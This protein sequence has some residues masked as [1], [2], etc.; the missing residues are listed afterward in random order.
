MLPSVTFTS[1]YCPPCTQ[2]TVVVPGH[3]GVMAVPVSVLLF[4]HWA[5][6]LCDPAH[7]SRNSSTIGHLFPAMMK[8]VFIS[9]IDISGCT[10]FRVCFDP[11]LLP[12]A[13]VRS[14]VL[15]VPG[16]DVL[17]EAGQVH[18]RTR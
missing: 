16:I 2:G 17:R 12:K 6:T 1:A 4:V 18:R 10:E 8:A 15:F 5:C 7:T 13:V 3:V 14:I 9:V 11:S